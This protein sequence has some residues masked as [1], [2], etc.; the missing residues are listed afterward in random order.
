MAITFRMGMLFGLFVASTVFMGGCEDESI[1]PAQKGADERIEADPADTPVESRTAKGSEAETEKPAPKDAEPEPATGGPARVKIETTM[2]DIVIELNEEK[3][4]VTTKNFLQYVKDGFYS[5]TIF[6]RVIPNFM[7]QGGGM[8]VDM[9]KKRTH[10]PIVNE[11]SNGLKNDRGTI[12]MARMD[13]PD[14]AT[15]Q[16][17]INHKNNNSLNYTG[18]GNPGYVVFGKVVSGLEVVDKIAGVKTAVRFGMPDVPV[19]PV[20]IKSVTVLP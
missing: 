8:T 10:S 15:S 1:D 4:P 5:G 11:A 6:H 2:G 17:F 14:S 7:I 19:E 18:P 3:A 20:I 13:P 9:V 12:A 16:F